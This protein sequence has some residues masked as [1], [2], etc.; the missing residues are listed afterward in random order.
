MT[1]I[2]P[3][4]RTI[5]WR[6][7]A[8]L[9]AGL[10]ACICVAG[11]FWPHPK[12]LPSP[13]R[14]VEP[15]PPFVPSPA[16]EAAN[17][18]AVLRAA[19]EPRC[20]AGRVEILDSEPSGKH[21]NRSSRKPGKFPEG[22]GCAGVKIVDS[23]ELEALFNKP[24]RGKIDFKHQGGWGNFYDAYPDSLGIINLSLPSYTSPTSAVVELGG[25][26]G[27]LCGSGW[28]ITLVKVNGVWTVHG[29]RP[30]WIS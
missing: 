4:R 26:C 22:L 21:G 2:L 7:V 3:V 13:P 27:R 30:T 8:L 14:I 5:S 9:S 12:K 15:P 11:F 16:F 1:R 23:G 18:L 10:V 24:Y 6:S 17:D 28:E 20:R 29:Q 25:T 19:L